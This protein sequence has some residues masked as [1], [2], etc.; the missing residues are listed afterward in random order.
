MSVS[1]SVFLERDRL[2]SPVEWQRALDEVKFEVKLDQEFDP[3]DFS[4][5]LS[6][7]YRDR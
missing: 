6:A 2:P 3:F 5:F 1:I 4:G 7:S